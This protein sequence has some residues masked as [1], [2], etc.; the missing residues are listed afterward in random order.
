M[1]GSHLALLCCGF[2][3]IV[4]TKASRPRG[5]AGVVF[6]KPHPRSPHLLGLLLFAFVFF[7][8]P[9]LAFVLVQLCAC[10]AL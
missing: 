6:F 8:L 3:P 2:T 5:S 10:I 7:V 4:A 1:A 9:K